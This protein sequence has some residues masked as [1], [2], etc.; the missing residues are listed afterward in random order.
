M[1]EK[2]VIRRVDDLGRVVIPKEFR[3]SLGL[4]DGL[5]VEI[6]NQGDSVVIR[7]HPVDGEVRPYLKNLERAVEKQSW[8][9]DGDKARILEMVKKIGSEIDDSAREK[10]NE[11]VF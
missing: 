7:P 1:K 6:L 11:S 4:S 3:E 10:G 9:E 8:I 5:P 2:G